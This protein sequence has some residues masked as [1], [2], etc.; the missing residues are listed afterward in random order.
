[1]RTAQVIASWLIA[2]A[3]YS[4]IAAFVLCIGL[5]VKHFLSPDAPAPSLTIL[6]VGVLLVGVVASLPGLMANIKLRRQQRAN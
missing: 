6:V 2:S 1:V 3:G 4:V 5:V